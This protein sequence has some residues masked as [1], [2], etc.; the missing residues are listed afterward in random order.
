MIYITN[1]L[2]YI[3]KD[4]INGD[5]IFIIN[6]SDMCVLIKIVLIILIIY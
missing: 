3:K 1:F 4:Y 2:K 6:I 5:I